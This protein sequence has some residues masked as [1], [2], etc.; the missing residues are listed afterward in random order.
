LTDEDLDP[1]IRDAE[2]SLIASFARGVL[3]DKAAVCVAI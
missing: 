2:K 1:R 3:K